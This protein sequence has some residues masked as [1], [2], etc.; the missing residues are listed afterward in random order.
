MVKYLI[1]Q[2]KKIVYIAILL[3]LLIL[4]KNAQRSN[5]DTKCTL[6]NLA[7]A[8]MQTQTVTIRVVVTNCKLQ[9]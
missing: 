1:L 4:K 8:Q 5:V 9:Y 3:Q 2:A 7:Y 6:R